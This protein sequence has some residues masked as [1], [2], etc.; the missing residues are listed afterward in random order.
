[1]EVV[2]PRAFFYSLLAGEQKSPVFAAAIG[3]KEAFVAA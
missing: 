1:M 3:R 2:L